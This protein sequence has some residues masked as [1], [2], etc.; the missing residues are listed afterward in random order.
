MYNTDEEIDNELEALRRQIQEEA[1]QPEVLQP[2]QEEALPQEPSEDEKLISAI[3]ALFEA[4]MNNDELIDAVTEAVNTSSKSF[5]A[6]YDADEL[7]AS[8][9]DIRQVYKDF[10][11]AS[12]LKC[13]TVFKRL[14]A[15]GIDVHSALL[16]SNKAYAECITD[17]IKRDAKREMADMLR[18]GKEHIMPE[19]NRK[20][21]MPEY[22]IGRLSD[23]EFEEIEK[24]VKQ[25][26][27]VFL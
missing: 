17:S 24:K 21:A 27:R 2:E 15:N 18:K 19:L 4:E 9:S 11:I 22:D 16:A 6:E 13:N 20:S 10:D 12:E 1:A 5:K 8:E 25:N 23:D 14:I 3:K 7:L 26:K